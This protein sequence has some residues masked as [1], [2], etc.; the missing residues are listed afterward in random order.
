MI[1]ASGYWSSAKEGASYAAQKSLELI[2]AIYPPLQPLQRTEA[3]ERPVREVR[4][5]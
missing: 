4:V 5:L 2:N 1:L 3:V